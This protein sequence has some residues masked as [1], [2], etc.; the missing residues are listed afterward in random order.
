MPRHSG[1][2]A[3][4]EDLSDNSGVRRLFC[5]KVSLMKDTQTYNLV[6]LAAGELHIHTLILLNRT[7]SSITFRANGWLV[8]QVI[9][10]IPTVVF[11]EIVRS[12]GV[13]CYRRTASRLS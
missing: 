8:A 3:F 4:L 2:T 6:G 7:G 12:Y 13:C 11:R 10:T 5:A 9:P 1:G